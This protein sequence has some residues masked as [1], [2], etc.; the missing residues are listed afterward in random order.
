MD[1]KKVLGGIAPTIATALGGPLAGTATKF[2]ANELLGDENADIEAAMLTA[3]P[4]QLAKVKEIE[5]QFKVKMKELDIDVYKLGVDD[6]KSARELAK[7]NMWPQI[8]LSFVFIKGYFALIL[9][10]FSGYLQLDDTVRDMANVLVG[11]LTAGI[12][13]ILRFW[14]GGSPNDD[15]HLD[16]IH[17]SK[18][19]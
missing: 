14:F 2:L 10:I 15:K 7:V 11:V 6:R 9:M 8:I 4:E 16:R 18:P 3:S 1:W 13:M 5:A 17:N 19:L 12:P